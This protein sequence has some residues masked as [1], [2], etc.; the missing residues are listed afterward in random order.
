MG[1]KLQ[2]Q[3]GPGD[4]ADQISDN[5]FRA[6]MQAN[7]NAM[8]E[9]QGDEVQYFNNL[10]TMVT[11]SKG[12]SGQLLY[13]DSKDMTD[14]DFLRSEL[15]EAVSIYCNGDVQNCHD[16]ALEEPQGK[17]IGILHTN[18]QKNEKIWKS[19][20]DWIEKFAGNNGWMDKIQKYQRSYDGKEGT[21]GA[22]D[23]LTEMVNFT[24]HKDNVLRENSAKEAAGAI[25]GLVDWIREASYIGY[26]DMSPGNPVLDYIVPP[27]ESGIEP[28]LPGG[29]P[30][31]LYEE[32]AKEYA[33]NAHLTAAIQLLK[34]GQTEPAGV[35]HAAWLRGIEKR[36]EKQARASQQKETD[37]V[38]AVNDALATRNELQLQYDKDIDTQIGFLKTHEL[39]IRSDSG[40]MKF[41]PE[42][43]GSI[44]SYITGTEFEVGSLNI[45]NIGGAKRLMAL[46]L[47]KW[48]DEYSRG[49]TSESWINTYNNVAAINSA[50]PADKQLARSD[51]NVMAVNAFFGTMADTDVSSMVQGSMRPFLGKWFGG[52]L[53]MDFPG[54]G[55]KET[56]AEEYMLQT[57]KVWSKM[58]E[59][60]LDPKLRVDIS[61]LTPTTTVDSQDPLGAITIDKGQYLNTIAPD[62]TTK[63]DIP[64][65][66][67]NPI[68]SLLQQQNDSTWTGTYDPS[69]KQQS[70]MMRG[71]EKFND[72][73]QVVAHRKMIVDHLNKDPM[74]ARP[75]AEWA[76]Y[77][78]NYL[79]S[80][81]VYENLEDYLKAGE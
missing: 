66:I 26:M 49:D 36:A 69:N 4:L 33:E 10:S 27:Y 80:M 41:D 37:R 20:Q 58:N 35:E 19:S 13:G 48:M 30:N 2:P 47:A 59:M 72:W 55:Q 44:Q 56:R 34:L 11:E 45:D 7:A 73:N 21:K 76:E 12:Y 62:D 54:T 15:G 78:S 75:E 24:K 23:I 60:Q 25:K 42:F 67:T 53:G 16:N 14:W 8:M 43:K 65:I 39:N 64:P 32:H 81:Y 28:V 9:M 79:D 22:G 1:I 46:N 77:Y 71:M 74:V 18:F 29:I 40:A 6:F 70:V 3:Y 63:V 51:L 17:L 52:G 31:P 38:T 50:L 57:Y 68:D 61:T 5:F